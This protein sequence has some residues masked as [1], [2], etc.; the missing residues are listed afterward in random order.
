MSRKTKKHSD[1]AHN[2]FNFFFFHLGQGSEHFLHARHVTFV[3]IKDELRLI[4][5]LVHCQFCARDSTKTFM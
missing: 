3:D 2:G 4:I 1:Q 5:S